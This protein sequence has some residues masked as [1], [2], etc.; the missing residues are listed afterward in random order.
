MVDRGESRDCQPTDRA[1]WRDCRE[2]VRFIPTKDSGRVTASNINNDLMAGDQF[3]TFTINSWWLN[4][5]VL[6][7]YVA[8]VV[9]EITESYSYYLLITSPPDLDDV[10]SE[11]FIDASPR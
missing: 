11:V 7:H 5:S 8:P 9:D 4:V 2:R 3:E 10:C 6:R 1:I